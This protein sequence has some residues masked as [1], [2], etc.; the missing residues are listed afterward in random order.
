MLIPFM[1]GV[2]TCGRPWY[3]CEVV[4]VPYMNACTNVCVGCEYEGKRVTEMLVL[5]TGEVLLG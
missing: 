5:G 4:L 1:C 3:V 2:Y